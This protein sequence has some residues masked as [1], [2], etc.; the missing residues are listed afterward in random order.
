MTTATRPP[1]DAA[2]LIEAIGPGRRDR[3]WLF[4]SP[5]LDDGVL[6]AGGV[7]AA[8]RRAGVDTV[9]A[10]V[11]AGTATGPVTSPFATE[12]VRL[13]GLG[14]DDPVGGRRAEDRA[15][16]AEVGARPVHLPVPDAIFRTTAG[17]GEALY[18][19]VEAVF[20]GAPRGDDPAIREVRRELAAVLAALE[21]AVVVGPAGIGGHV[22][23]VLVRDAVTA[24]AGADGPVLML[25]ED[26]PYAAT[27]RTPAAGLTALPVSFTEADWD[28]KAAAAARYVSQLPAVWPEADGLAELRARA[29]AVGGDSTGPAEL[30][31]CSEA[32]HALVLGDPTV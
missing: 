21:P 19:T 28:A 6:S 18:P 15:A 29:E 7:L 13:W 3:P 24:L 14:T 11:F 17:T 30:L 5:H 26:L 22:D 23:H 4:V 31:W 20:A 32:A 9:V 27:G 2:A 25:Y 12:L 16:L 10:T 8:A 1:I